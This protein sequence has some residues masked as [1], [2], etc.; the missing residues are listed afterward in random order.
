M[1]VLQSVKSQRALYNEY[2]MSLV[3]CWLDN[4]AAVLLGI[5][6]VQNRLMSK[7][8]RLNLQQGHPLN[9]KLQKKKDSRVKARRS[10]MRVKRKASLFPYVSEDEHGS[11]TSI[12]SALEEDNS[13]QELNR[14]MPELSFQAQLKRMAEI[15]KEFQSEKMKILLQLEEQQNKME[16]KSPSKS[17]RLSLLT[18]DNVMTE[19]SHQ[20]LRDRAKSAGAVKMKER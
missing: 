6:P 19:G 3:Q 16:V 7:T 10:T 11:T 2:R 17:R 1:N 8:M 20:R 5:D 18:A 12:L 9:E 15:E 14:S 4:I 13:P